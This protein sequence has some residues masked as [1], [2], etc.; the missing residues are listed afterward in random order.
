MSSSIINYMIRE[1]LKKWLPKPHALEKKANLG[2]L[3]HFLTDPMLW[4]LNRR[5]IARGLSIGFFVAFLPLPAQ[6][7]LAACL[8]IYFRGNLPLAILGTWI[9]NPFTFLPFNF[10]V[11]KTGKFFTGQNGNPPPPVSF[12]FSWHLEQWPTLAL[13][14]LQWLKQLGKPF[15][16][17]IPITAFCAALIA[18]VG[19][20]LVW[21]ILITWQWR[22]RRNHPQPKG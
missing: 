2:R 1:F 10:L 11:Y 19:T 6:M 3:K 14:F 9:T 16:I 8:A 7:L 15:L 12:D 5:A 21:R 22:H 18:Y 17:G 13:Q 4:H 20:L